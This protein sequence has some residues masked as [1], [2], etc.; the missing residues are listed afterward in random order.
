MAVS[1]A[2]KK[3]FRFD[4]AVAQAQYSSVQASLATQKSKALQMMDPDGGSPQS[5]SYML[6]AYDIP[7]DDTT[8]AFVRNIAARQL[9]DGRWRPAGFRPPMENDVSTTA[10]AIRA[11]QRYGTPHREVRYQRQIEKAATWLAR[12]EPR[13]TEERVFQLLAFTWTHAD[14]QLLRKRAAELLAEQREDGGWS[15]LPSLESDA[16]ATGETLYA[17][18]ES[19]FLKGIDA[20]YQRGVGF[21]LQTQAADGSWFV[22]TRALSLQP[23]LDAGFPYGKDQFV[24]AAGTSWAAMALML[25]AQ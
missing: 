19:G 4:Q 17:L 13:F 12:F 9:P 2:R 7:S 8:S 14:P 20:A 22:K 25:D 6:L 23:H 18:E 10:L 3:G 1:L 16:Y 15:Q 11:I 24:S 5:G 21:L